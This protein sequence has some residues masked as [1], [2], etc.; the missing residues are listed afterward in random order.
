MKPGYDPRD[1]T[2]GGP[3]TVSLAADDD[4]DVRTL[5]LEQVRAGSGDVRLKRPAKPRRDGSEPRLEGVGEAG[6]ST[7]WGTVWKTRRVRGRVSVWI[8][9]AL[10]I[11]LPER[12]SRRLERWRRPPCSRSASSA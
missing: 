5:P 1:P 2:K 3:P 9:T 8:R 10:E 12:G 4:L 6:A 7:P 11:R